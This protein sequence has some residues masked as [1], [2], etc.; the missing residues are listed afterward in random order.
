MVSET[1]PIKKLKRENRKLKEQL[2]LARS[3]LETLRQRHGEL[4]DNCKI[5]EQLIKDAYGEKVNIDFDR[6]KL[7]VA[8]KCVE[9]NSYNELLI[10][11]R[12]IKLFL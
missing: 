1:D 4:M 3:E 7:C 5:M 12:I 6:F 11:L 2:E 8:E 10:A 9:F